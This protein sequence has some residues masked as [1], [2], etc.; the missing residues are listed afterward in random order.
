MTRPTRIGWPVDVPGAEGNR[1][2]CQVAGPEDGPPVV[3]TSGIGCGPVFY[4]HIAPD[5]ARDHC[6]VYWDFRAHGASDLAPDGRSYAIVDQA[7]DLE[8][9]VQALTRRPPVMVGFSMGVQVT[10]EW[11]RR[12][13]GSAP[14]YVFLLG[15]PCNPL[16]SHPA[17]GNRRLQRA[18]K[19]FL[20]AGPGAA[21]PLFHPLSKATLRSRISYPMA[22]RWGLITSSFTKEDY[23]EFVRYSSAVRPDAY[24]RTGLG[25]LEHDG[26]DFWREL[27]APVLFIA[28]ERDR[29]VPAR[30]CSSVAPLLTNGVYEE[31]AGASHAGTVE[32]GLALARRVRAFVESVERRA[33][34]LP[35]AGEPLDEP[36]PAPKAARDS[37][38]A[39]ERPLRAASA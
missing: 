16:R 38:T 34:S 14:G 29:L 2:A 25:V 4:R 8:A 22:V 18:A 26:I 1:I 11:A 3:L 15:M 27:A 24:L 7:R 30:E 33:A 19:A 10:V 37:A 36:L 35:A 39:A 21:L 17:F 9:V 6:V 28:A 5:L 32:A 31:L 23:A 13:A 12:W 20:D